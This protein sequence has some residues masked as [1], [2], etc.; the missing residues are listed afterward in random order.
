[1]TEQ[2]NAQ[3]NKNDCYCCCG[4]LDFADTFWQKYRYHSGKI[5]IGISV[6]GSV[7][8]ILTGQHLI[9]GSIMVGI[10]NV[11]VFFSGLA[12]EKLNNQA[13]KL[14]DDCESQRQMIRKLTMAPRFESETPQSRES[15]VT[16]EPINFELMHKNNVVN[17]SMK[18]YNFPDDE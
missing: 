6:L 7:S 13:K 4:L 3:E 15:N 5:S 18:N 2:E 11:S 8:A 17:N 10:T 16:V 9:T 14:N 1:M 12:Y